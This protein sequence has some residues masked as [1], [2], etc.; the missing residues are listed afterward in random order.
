MTKFHLRCFGALLICCLLSTI[1]FAQANAPTGSLS[2]SDTVRAFYKAMRERHF[3]EG[4]AMSI[5]KPA[6]DGLNPEEFAELQPDFEKMAATVPATVEISGEQISGEFAT[7][8]VKDTEADK[9]GAAVPVA[10]LRMNSAWIIGNKEDQEIVSKAGKRFFFEARIETHQNDV[11]DLLR[12]L[13][14]VQLAYSQQHN[15]V[16]ADLPTLISVGLMP[17][18]IEGTESTGYRFHISLAPDAKS[19]LAGAE[20]ARYGRSGRLSFSI[21]QT[22]NIKSQ[23][24][25]GL[26][27]K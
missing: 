24:I 12:R 16:F 1:G 7:V 14:V 9:G 18:D 17:K 21:D 20:P 4:F 5:Y 8:F 2:P 10:L 27:L 19:Y 26:P 25:A 23:D 13:M 11:M 6:L 15:G 3:R 22:G